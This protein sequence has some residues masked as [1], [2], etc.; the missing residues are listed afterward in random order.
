M[1][2]IQEPKTTEVRYRKQLFS[3]VEN[4]ADTVERDVVPILKQFEREYVGDSYTIKLEEVF[5]R[6]A[7][8]FEEIDKQAKT[9]ANSFVEEVN[10]NNKKR[11]Y[12]SIES[13]I[14]VNLGSLIQN[15]G[16]EDRLKAT[17][18]M[19]VDLIK[20]IPEE[21]LK[22]VKTIIYTNTIQGENAGSIIDQIRDVKKVSKNRARVIARDQTSKLNSALT[23]KRAKNVGSEEYIWRT[24]GDGDRVRPSHRKNN[25][26]TFRW[27]SPPKD[28]GHPGHDIQCR[29]IAQPIIKVQ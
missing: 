20:S 27:D 13:S 11:F 24:V 12:S 17:V 6:M 8:S 22:K 19:N 21:Y 9:V 15:E 18:D 2:P 23:Q 26:K 1:R 4:L 25:G 14:G 16:L 28:T 3:L 7:T 29:C 10:T 5:E